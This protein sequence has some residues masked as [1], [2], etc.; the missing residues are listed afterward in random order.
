MGKLGWALVAVSLVAM[1]VTLVAWIW[2]GGSGFGANLVIV[3]S[4]V[5]LVAGINL[6]M[7]ARRPGKG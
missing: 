2:P 1:S 6:I 3:A 4:F 7:A 5:G